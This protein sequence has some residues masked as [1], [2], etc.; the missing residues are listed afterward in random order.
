MGN[1]IIVRADGRILNRETEQKLGSAQYYDPGP[2]LSLIEAG[3]QASRHIRTVMIAS[4][5]FVAAYLSTYAAPALYSA[6]VAGGEAGFLT[7][8]SR[9]FEI[10]RD[11]TGKVH[12]E[13][14]KL[15]PKYVTREQLEQ[16]AQELRASIQVRQQ[17]M[18]RLGEQGNHGLRIAKEQQLL[19]RIEQRLGKR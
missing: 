14:P 18:V 8:G 7:I 19:Y 15:I 13:L 12:G 16:A 3:T 4:S 1:S 9:T 2:L 6:L 5:V 17:M 11:A 10:V